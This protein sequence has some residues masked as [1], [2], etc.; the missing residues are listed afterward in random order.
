MKIQVIKS[1]SF[2]LAFTTLGLSANLYAQ[3]N[4]KSEEK[5][6][7]RKETQAAMKESARKLRTEIDEIKE[8]HRKGEISAE[9]MN[10]QIAAASER[11]ASEME[12]LSKE[13]AENIKV[14][15][16]EKVEMKGR[17]EK[18]APP[19]APDAPGVRIEKDEETG[20]SKVKVKVKGKPKSPRR[21]ETGFALT[22]GRNTM[23][24]EG[25]PTEGA[26]YPETEFWRGGYSEWMVFANTRIGGSRSPLYLNYGLSLVYNKTDLGATS[27]L[28][29]ADG[30]P[31]FEVPSGFALTKNRFENHYLNAQLGFK[32]APKRNNSFHIEANGFVGARFRTKQV[33]EYTTDLNERVKESRR[34]NYGTNAFNYGISAAIGY[35]W[36]SLFARY[37]LSSLFKDN[38]VY[39]FR[40][41][42]AGIR[43]NLI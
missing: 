14:E 43:F 24:R 19:T 22:L 37:E 13:L 7:D 32:F 2:V 30:R 29:I 10:D 31:S 27:R 18:P 4:P 12:A 40:P 25:P 26:L 23:F 38:S 41:F 9:E 6:S 1:I 21:T 36:V 33:L 11:M 16:E 34:N 5:R 8:R 3:D 39:D 15:V 20:E 28:N 42:S 17:R 35:D